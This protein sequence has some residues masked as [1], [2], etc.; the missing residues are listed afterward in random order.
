MQTVSNA[1]VI[2]DLNDTLIKNSVYFREIKKNIAG[3]LLKLSLV[4]NKKDFTTDRLIHVFDSFEIKNIKAGR[5]PGYENFRIS[6]IQACYDILQYDFIQCKMYDFID[7]QVS[8]VVN[9]PVELIDDAKDVLSYLYNKNYRLFIVSKGNKQEQAKKIKE[10][11]IDHFFEDIIFLPNKDA[12][13][14]SHFV[15][16]YNI[17]INRAYMVGNSPKSDINPAK[18]IGMKTFFIKNENTWEYEHDEILLKEPGTIIIDKISN[19]K[20]FL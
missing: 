15:N 20:D 1:T 12:E 10:G 11:G 13:N 8:H 18:R 19:L 17:D 7:L 2:F 3:Q 14:Y 5:K 4:N 16:L 6:L 9:R